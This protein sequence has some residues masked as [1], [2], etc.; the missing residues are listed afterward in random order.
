MTSKLKVNSLIA[1]VTGALGQ[2]RKLPARRDRTSSNSEQSS[3]AQAN[4][5][6]AGL[7]GASVDKLVNIGEP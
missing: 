1:R 3:P 5:W 6:K 2:P 4:Q 7:K